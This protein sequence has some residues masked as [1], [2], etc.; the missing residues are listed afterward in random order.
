[1]PEADRQRLLAL[2]RELSYE[3]RDVI[4]ASGRRSNFYVDCRNT[5]LHPE[6]MTLCGVL[7]WEALTRSGPSFAAVAGPSVG[8]D[9]LVCSVVRSSWESGAG[10][11][12]LFIRKEPKGHGTGRLIEG[13][14]NVPA[15][16]SVA[17]LE[18]VLTS[19]GSA[20]RAIGALREAGYDP[21][22]LLV[23]VDRCEGGRER[24]SADGVVVQSLFDR[25]LVEGG[26]C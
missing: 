17:V 9:P 11:A 25:P 24:V 14:R 12:G 18:D 19:G 16:S 1:M 6:G 7:M 15:G 3:K 10:V 22:R 20:L 8:A 13:G 5:T 21:V 23:L 2:L 4:L 26:A